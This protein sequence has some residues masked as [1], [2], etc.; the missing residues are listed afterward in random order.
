MFA[1]ALWDSRLRTLYLC[2]D[3]CGKKPLYYTTSKDGLLFASELPALRRMLPNRPQLSTQALCLYM[4]LGF[5]PSPLTIEREIR[6]V[7]P[8][9]VLIYGPD[10]RPVITQYWKPETTERYAGTRE[11][12][13]KQL[14]HELRT[15]IRLRLRSDVP[16]GVFLSGGIDSGLVAA[17][18]A[19]E[20]DYSPV[21]FIASNTDPQLDESKT[22]QK[23]AEHLGLPA[24]I[25][26]IDYA[27]WNLIQQIPKL[28]GQPFADP[29]A[30]PSLL[31]ARAAHGRRKVVLSGDGG[32]E[33]FAGYRRYQLARLS[34]WF[35]DR[36]VKQAG[37]FES[38]AGLAGSSA[39]RSPMGFLA[40][41]CRGLAVGEPDRYLIWT[42][43]ML[44]REDLCRLLPDLPCDEAR[45]FLA[46]RAS[47][48]G[49][50]RFQLSDYRLI[51]GDCLL[52]KMDIAS[53]ASSVEVRSPL[54]DT[55]LASFAWSLPAAWSTRPRR[56][57]ALLRDLAGGYLPPE[58]VTAP[59]R[60]FEVPIAGWLRTDLS[61]MVEEM[62]LSSGSQLADMT[63]ANV[64]ASLV[65]G[66]DGFRGNRSLVVWALLILE[67][68]LRDR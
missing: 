11:Q 68:F 40:R 24:E 50:R 52:P 54:L 33:V 39:R 22:A 53:M 60:G 44:G 1:F 57:K 10:R 43:D 59:K 4:Q 31:V 7:P 5:V 67:L 32:D 34:A 35:G 17:Y 19:R 9:H 38:L 37:F 41:A 6:A 42:L 51:L 64:L 23:V 28:Y 47:T 46:G 45:V 2:R 63:D 27:P 3:R 30:I 55:S 58:V 56:P 16:V 26:D 61:P 15:S 36:G 48:G 49:L 8:G 29:S 62:L 18:A 14:D 66:D 21:C 13:L 12:A 65:R 25:V 20:A